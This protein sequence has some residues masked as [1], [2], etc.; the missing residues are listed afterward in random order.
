MTAAAT[1]GTAT[2]TYDQARSTSSQHKSKIVLTSESREA[3]LKPE[4]DRFAVQVAQRNGMP[5][6]RRSQ[7]IGPYPIS[8][9]VSDTDTEIMQDPAKIVGYAVEWHFVAKP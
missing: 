5:D 8:A 3:L 2:V 1:P 9:N 4:A 7:K 6:P